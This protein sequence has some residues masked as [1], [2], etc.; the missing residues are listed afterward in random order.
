VGFVLALAAG[1]L[2]LLLWAAGV[3]PRGP[4]SPAQSR[5]FP[6]SR[7]HAAFGK[8]TPQE[9]R[10]RIEAAAEDHSLLQ[11]TAL[12]DLAAEDFP[13]LRYRFADFPSTLEL[14]LVFR[15]RESPDDVQ[16]ISLPAP[17]TRGGTID[18]SRV[19]AWRGTLVEIGFA[20]FPVAQLVPP[21]EGFKPFSLVE[22]KLESMS[23]RGRISAMFTSWFARAPW[24]L[25]SVSAIGPSETGDDTP[26]SPRPPLV[27]A[28]ALGVLGMLAFCVLRVRGAALRRVMLICAVAAWFA[29]DFAWLVDLRY[30]LAVD[31]DIWGGI[32]FA[33]RQNYVADA[34]IQEVAMRLK[35]ALADEPPTTRILV[36][37]G[38]PHE[39]LRLIYLAAPLNLGAFAGF[40]NS[41]QARI[42]S[43]TLIVSYGAARARAVNGVMKVGIRKLRV[44]T[45]ER[46]DGFAIYRVEAVTR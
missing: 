8:A 9:Q 15:T 2:L 21:D 3:D 25:I 43:G 1:W 13:I 26:H 46:G 23:W 29:L 35:A 44:S 24:Q 39:M 5:S 4:L 42:S 27:L 18:L 30:K 40:A 22:S 11:V 19:A 28:L 6:G 45:M 20:Q 7:H 31:R 10:L 14:S 34:Q 36:S 41:P 38:S 32:P 16:T 33:Q 12:P 17:G 37:A